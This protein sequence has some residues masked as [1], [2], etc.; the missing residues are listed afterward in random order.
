MN[1][2]QLYNQQNTNIV[3]KVQLI[4]RYISNYIDKV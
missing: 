3:Y 4:N 1:K 2:A